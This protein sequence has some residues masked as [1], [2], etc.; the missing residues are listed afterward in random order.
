MIKLFQTINIIFA[1]VYQNCYLK[2]H[3]INSNS[4]AT[5]IILVSIRYTY[6]YQN[7]DQFIYTFN[8]NYYYYWNYNVHCSDISYKLNVY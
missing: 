5:Y 3:L 2:N 4:L 7:Y 1:R 6:F 8:F